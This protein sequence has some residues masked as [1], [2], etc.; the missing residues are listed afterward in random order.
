[1]IQGSAKLFIFFKF[2]IIHVSNTTVTKHFAIYFNSKMFEYLQKE[3][4][5][6]VLPNPAII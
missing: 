5:I 1:M 3:N 2:S 6:I 4:V